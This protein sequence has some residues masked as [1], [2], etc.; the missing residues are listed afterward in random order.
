MNRLLYI[1]ILLT[2]INPLLGQ[3][4]APKEL[5]VNATNLR[6]REEPNQNA[7][8]ID[9]LK[10]GEF[11]EFKEF[12][13]HSEPGFN[14]YEKLIYSWL[15]VIRKQDGKTGFVYGQFVQPSCLAL[16][17][18]QDYVKLPNLNWY[19]I[20]LEN[21]KPLLQISEPEIVGSK[22]NK[23]VIDSLQSYIII[24]TKGSYKEGIID[25]TVFHNENIFMLKEDESKVIEFQNKYKLKIEVCHDIEFKSEMSEVKIIQRLYVSIFNPNNKEILNQ[26]LTKQF[27]HM[28]NLGFWIHFIGDI[29][30]DFLPEMLISPINEKGGR[31]LWFESRNNQIKLQS[32]TEYGT[33]C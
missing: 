26:E 15:K 32:I 12:V 31:N 29:N 10:D 1:L 7:H 27:N 30:K 3:D 13:A 19:G 4:F 20:T 21:E 22:F 28:N 18:G 2:F 33:G 9:V 8:I 5:I 16:R 24:G 17:Y 11:L 14:H 23:M 6:F 25:G